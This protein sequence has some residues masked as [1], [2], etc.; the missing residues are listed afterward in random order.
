ML[1]PCAIVLIVILAGLLWSVPP[2][3]A[4]VDAAGAEF[5]LPWE[6]GRKVFTL[7]GQKQGS[8][9]GASQQYAYDFSLAQ[10]DGSPFTVVAAR[11]GMVKALHQSS[12]ASPD[13]DIRFYNLANFVLLD[14]GDGSGTLYSHLLKASALVAVGQKVT[15]GQPLARSDH[16]GYVCG[17]GHL[18]FAVLDFKTYAGLDRPFADRDAQRDGGRPRTG[19][20][21]TSDAGPSR[22]AQAIVPRVF[23]PFLSRTYR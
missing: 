8:H 9:T 7:Q 15:Q 20:W 17:T 10:F 13:C 5:F 23:L 19:Q 1:L 11:A 4:A 3:T 6:G 21:Y 16:T 14:H 2:Q 18:H 22:A 12:D